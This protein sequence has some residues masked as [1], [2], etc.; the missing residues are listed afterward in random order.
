MKGKKEASKRMLTEIQASQLSD[1]EF[2]NNAYKE[3]QGA[4]REL[5]ETTGKLQ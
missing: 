2:K 5:P 3:V 1:T 4:Q